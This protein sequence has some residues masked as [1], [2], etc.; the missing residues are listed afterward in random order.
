MNKDLLKE[1]IQALRTFMEIKTMNKYSHL[2]FNLNINLK[3]YD[4]FCIL[5][6]HGPIVFMQIF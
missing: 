1:M 3:F 5:S 2:N 6:N 4:N